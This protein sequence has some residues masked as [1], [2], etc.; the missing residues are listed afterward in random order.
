MFIDWQSLILF[1]CLSLLY[2]SMGRGE[3]WRYLVRAW[4]AYKSQVWRLWGNRTERTLKSHLSFIVWTH[5]WANSSRQIAAR[6]SPLIQITE[7]EA[8][9]ILFTCHN[10]VMCFIKTHSVTFKL[11]FVDV[12]SSFVCQMFQC[13]V[14]V[15]EKC[16]VWK[17]SCS[18]CFIFICLG[19]GFYNWT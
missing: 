14:P 19:L 12:D 3:I 11:S 13:S 6:H 7:V 5:W 10:T 17:L 18:F 9:C 4:S 1:S 16:I 8:V 2:Y 15:C